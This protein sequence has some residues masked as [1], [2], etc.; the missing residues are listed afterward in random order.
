MANEILQNPQAEQQAGRD[1]KKDKRTASLQMPS[2]QETQ[3]QNKRQM[4]SQQKSALAR[5]GSEGQTNQNVNDNKRNLRAEQRKSEQEEKPQ[6]KLGQIEEGA[7]DIAE[8]GANMLTAQALKAAWLNL[9]DSLG[10]TLIYI[11]FHFIGKYFANSSY[12]CDFGEEWVLKMPGSDQV[13]GIGTAKTGLKY[14]EII[15]LFLLDVLVCI[16]VLAAITIIIGPIIHILS[17]L[18]ILW[19]WL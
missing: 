17:W 6:G 9:I 19:G 13:P 11:N 8:K 16:I 5:I 7:K 2:G 10:L 12:F 18:T 15:G 14:A 1:I 4:S 3:E